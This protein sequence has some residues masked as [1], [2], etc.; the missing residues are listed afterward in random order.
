[1]LTFLV[2]NG[3]VIINLVI[4]ILATVYSTFSK[5]TRGLYYDTLITQLPINQHHKFYGAMT[6][7]PQIASPVMVLISPLLYFL[8]YQK[9][10]LKKVNNFLCMIFYMP[11]ALFSII[12]FTIFNILCLPFAYLLTIRGKIKIENW[13]IK[14]TR[15]LP[16]PKNARTH[17]LAFIFIGPPQILYRLV[18]DVIKFSKHLFKE[19]KED[20]VK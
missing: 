3:V 17:W 6:A 5:N 9:G 13:Q 15:V 4:A 2:I 18:V 12:V 7:A 20:E 16:S 14:Y 8:R 11:I 1:M 19:V 10:S